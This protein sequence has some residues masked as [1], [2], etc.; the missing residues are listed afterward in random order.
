MNPLLIAYKCEKCLRLFACIDKLDQHSKICKG[1]VPPPAKPKDLLSPAQ[2]FDGLTCTALYNEYI[3][4]SSLPC[5]VCDDAMTLPSVSADVHVNGMD[6]LLSISDRSFRYC[7]KTYC[8][9]CH[10]RSHEKSGKC[11]KTTE[12]P[13]LTL[14]CHKCGPKLIC[15]GVKY[16]LFNVR[17]AIHNRQRKQCYESY[18]NHAKQYKHHTRKPIH[19]LAKPNANGFLLKQSAFRSMLKDYIA[20]NLTVS[21]K[22]VCSFM[23]RMKRNRQTDAQQYCTAFLDILTAEPLVRCRPAMSAVVSGQHRRRKS[24][25]DLGAT[26]AERL[27]RSSLTKANRA[28]SPAGSPDFCKLVS[29]FSRGSPVYPAPSFRR[30]FIFTSIA[31]VGSQDL[32]VFT[33]D[34][35]KIVAFQ[36]CEILYSEIGSSIG[37]NETTVKWLWDQRI[38]EGWTVLHAGSQ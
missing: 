14:S 22:D 13:Y 27:R 5:T 19:V 7:G 8:K 11:M 4:M 17:L 21:P 16:I 36:D 3:N 32:A 25:K 20:A 28:Q 2:T 37:R 18:N 24:F 30:R 29:G 31:L 6:K 38:E 33:F 15:Y 35:R 23:S 10:A 34:H 1:L 9:I 26:V 12:W